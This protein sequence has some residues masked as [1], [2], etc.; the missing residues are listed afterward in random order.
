MTYINSDK[1]E[2]MCKPVRHVGMRIDNPV[3]NAPI[4]FE[5]SQLSTKLL[6]EAIKT[7]QSIN[8]T[9]YENDIIAKKD[10]AQVLKDT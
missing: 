7:G 4:A 9:E 3:F 5:R 1:K 8:L 6:T 2:L 10:Q